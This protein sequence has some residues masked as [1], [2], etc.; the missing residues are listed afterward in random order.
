MLF[1]QGI[2]PMENEDWFQQL[3]L[4][5]AVS[6]GGG[7]LGA[8]FNA[9]HKA[10]FKARRCH[11]RK[12]AAVTQQAVIAG[13]PGQ[14]RLQCHPQAHVQGAPSG[15]AQG[16][17]WDMTG[18]RRMHAGLWNAACT[19]YNQPVCEAAPKCAVRWLNVSGAECEG[20][21]SARASM[22]SS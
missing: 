22:R 16:P 10:M 8:I 6:L 20:R 13:M 11:M 19:C 21:G 12:S 1:S 5:V 9:A 3:P 4:F 17:C 2:A 7:L 18:R 15:H 14:E